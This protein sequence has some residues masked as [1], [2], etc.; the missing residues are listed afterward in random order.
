MPGYNFLPR[1]TLKLGESNVALILPVTGLP[2]FSQRVRT[3]IAK[4]QTIVQLNIY[5]PDGTTA[6]TYAYDAPTCRPR[7]KSAAF[8]VVYLGTFDVVGTWRYRVKLEMANST[9]AYSDY[10]TLTVTAE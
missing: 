8:D 4:K 6:A 3:Q 5:K 1:T 2:A 9:V 10:S 7:R